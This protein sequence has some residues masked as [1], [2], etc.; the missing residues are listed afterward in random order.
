M[1]KDRITFNGRA[2][3]V[4]PFRYA[5]KPIS[6]Q[7]AGLPPSANSIW[8]SVNG[9]VLRSAE[10]RQWLQA[11][12]WDIKAQAGSRRMRGAYEAEIIFGRPDK[13]RRDLD[14][15]I[16][17]L[18]DALVEAGVVRDDSLCVRIVASWGSEFGTRI[19]ITSAEQ[20]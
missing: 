13:R 17:P 10:Y 20:P 9:K 4:D 1:S 16:K 3:A 12:A 2:V 8:R 11:T 7:L 5:E 15:R 14:N 19:V 6:L 18:S